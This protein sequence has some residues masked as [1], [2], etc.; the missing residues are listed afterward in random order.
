MRIAKLISAA[1]SGLALL[2]ACA[3]SQTQSPTDQ[4]ELTT[5][6]NSGPAGM[7]YVIIMDRILKSRIGTTDNNTSYRKGQENP[8]KSIR[9]NHKALAACLV[10]DKHAISVNHITWNARMGR[11]WSGVEL[12][13]LKECR[14]NKRQKQYSCVCQIVDHDGVNVLQVPADFLA[15]HN[16]HFN[17]SGQ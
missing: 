9:G 11:D 13:A 7:Y 12:G 5:G 4:A 15:E 10:W 8:Y 17:P 3:P 2:S 6:I 1:C 16:K 14:A